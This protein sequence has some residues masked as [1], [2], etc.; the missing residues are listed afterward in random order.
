MLARSGTIK[1]VVV[2][3]AVE[4]SAGLRV[5]F[6]RVREAELR[7][8]LMSVLSEGPYPEGAGRVQESFRVA[9]G[10]ETAARRLVALATS[11]AQAS[12]TA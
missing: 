9:G 8:L 7:A 10:T 5:R 4:A 12:A 11:S 3:Q 1:P 2:G 6:G